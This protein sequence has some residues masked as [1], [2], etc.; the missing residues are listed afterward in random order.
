MQVDVTIAITVDDEAA[1][2]RA[3]HDRA[4][5]DELGQEE[6]ETYL[7]AD[8]TTVGECAIM[9]LD[10]GVSPNGCSILES[11]SNQAE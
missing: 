8:L 7:N 2:R 5:A 4:V 10:P 3:A 6:A 1:F 9:L 11:T